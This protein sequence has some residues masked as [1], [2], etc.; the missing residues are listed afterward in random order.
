MGQIGYYGKERFEVSKSKVLTLNDFQRSTAARFESFDR[1]GLKPLTEYKGSGL[2]II[3]F[4]IKVKAALGVNP[5]VVLDNWTNLAS[6]GKPDVLV[7]GNKAV[8][9]DQWVVK[10]TAENWETFDGK[11]NVLTGTINLTFE[12]YMRK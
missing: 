11:G 6:A 5:R 3:T 10:S 2:D 8:G 12:E 4:A 7:I 9:T 1:I